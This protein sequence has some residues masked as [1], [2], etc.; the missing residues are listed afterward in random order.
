MQS[1]QQSGFAG[2]S[3][4]GDVIDPFEAAKRDVA[5]SKDLAASATEDL[6]QH[7][8]WLKG[9]LAAEARNREKHTRRLKRQQ[10]MQ[11]RLLKRQRL[12]RSFRRG[13]LALVLLLRS[14]SLS[15]LKGAFSTLI[16]LRDWLLIGCARIALSIRTAALSL[17]RLLA[18]SASWIRQKTRVLAFAALRA[19]SIGAAWI[20]QKTRVLALATFRATSVSAARIGQKTQVLALAT[21][22]A[23]SI[24]AAWIGQKGR[25]LVRMFLEQAQTSHL[26]RSALGLSLAPQPCESSGLQSEAEVRTAS[27]VDHDK[28]IP[29]RDA[30]LARR[31]ST[32]L[33]CI[34]PPRVGL[35]V[36]Q[37][38]QMAT[39]AAPKQPPVIGQPPK[40]KRKRKKKKKNY[41][42]DAINVQPLL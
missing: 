22:R 16:Y 33:V 10:V 42:S 18:I 14:I 32:E 38:T 4:A 8:R 1:G 26:T 11:E 2:V 15:L 19:A 28:Q 7:H 5:R 6:K 12:I 3:E 20:G 24:S 39:C 13:A 27:N 37:P 21:F 31:Q 35:P 34:V 17:L 30:G 9:T 23:T 41:E 25:A 40:R 29:M 36:V